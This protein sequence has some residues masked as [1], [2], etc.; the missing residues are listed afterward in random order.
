MRAVATLFVAL[1]LA[2]AYPAVAAGDCYTSTTEGQVCHEF[3]VVEPV[4]TPYADHYY[5]WV[6]WGDCTPSPLTANCLGKPAAPGSGVPTPSGAVGAGQF[7]LL[8]QES[9][10]CPGL[11]RF[12][13]AC[14]GVKPAD[15]MILV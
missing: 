13:V 9:N 12:T 3:D 2:G 11:Q 6:S 7:G 8:Y 1:I 4:P 5:L 10:A 15:R 14:G